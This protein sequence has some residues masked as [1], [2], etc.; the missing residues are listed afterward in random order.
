MFNRR[1]V[2]L[3]GGALLLA[4][5]TPL[6]QEAWPSGPIRLIIPFSPGGGNDTLGRMV[7]LALQDRLK[8]SVVADNRAGAGGV[9]GMSALSNAPANGYTVA[10]CPTGPLDVSPWINSALPYDPVQGFT[11]VANLIKFP[12]FLCVSPRTGV[13]SLPELLA[14]A[15][16]EPG[17]LTFS[18]GGIANST[19]L[20]G[21]VLADMTQTKLLHVP[22]KGGGPAMLAVVSGEV[23]MTFATGPAAAGFVAS[24][25]VLNLGTTDSRRVPEMPDVPTIAEQGVAEYDVTSFSGILGPSGMPDSVVERLAQTLREI[26]A[27]SQFRSRLSSQGMVP[28]FM[29]GTAFENYVAQE[30]EKWGALIQ[31]RQLKLS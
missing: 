19:H 2:L 7:A 21:E 24:G 26:L 18:S 27:N 4:T 13:K 10:T 22:Y 14:K 29:E 17:K 6:A 5:R 3:A 1:E 8:A 9:V 23:D 31:K 25:Q 30:R 16:A 11:Y 12:L 28:T 15:R 20:A